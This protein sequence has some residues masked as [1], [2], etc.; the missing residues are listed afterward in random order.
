MSTIQFPES[1]GI[2]ST[3][4]F[5]PCQHNRDFPR[6]C[7]NNTDACRKALL[8]QCERIDCCAK[9]IERKFSSDETEMAECSCHPPCEET[10]YDT[11]Y[12]LSQWSG[13]GFEDD[14]VWHDIFDD[15]TIV[16]RFNDST[17]ELNLYREYFSYE[18]WKIAKT[19]FA[20][21]NVYMAD[22]TMIQTQ[23]SPDYEITDLIS[24]VG[25]QLGVW[26]GMS[27]VTM[28]E[29]FAL[30]GQLLRYFLCK[31]NLDDGQSSAAEV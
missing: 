25:G 18:N 28:I 9:S 27:V 11:S 24:D 1:F 14:T 20:R 15:G 30:F 4:T 22:S 8:S 5:L 21:I 12:S 29:T 16:N 26:I 19:D 7:S 31:K 10:V 2:N 13:K 6:D 3:E 23:E 17:F